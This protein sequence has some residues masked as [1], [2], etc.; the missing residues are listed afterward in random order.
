MTG[1]SHFCIKPLV[2][3]RLECTEHAVWP[4][5]GNPRPQISAKNPGMRYFRPRVSMFLF[6]FFV[7]KTLQ[8][9]SHAC[10]PSLDLR[11]L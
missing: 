8:I 9:M 11:T 4:T 7:S 5:W 3:S 1:I 10:T 2:L 6:L